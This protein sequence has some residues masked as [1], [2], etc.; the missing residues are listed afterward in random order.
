MKIAKKLACLLLTGM[1]LLAQVPL[2]SFAGTSESGENAGDFYFTENTLTITSKNGFEL[3]DYLLNDVSSQVLYDVIDGDVIKVDENG[4]VTVVGNGGPVT[5]TARAEMKG[6]DTK[7]CTISTISTL[8]NGQSTRSEISTT[9]TVEVLY[10]YTTTMKIKVNLPDEESSG[11]DSSS[12]GSSG[13]GGGRSGLS[14]AANGGTF[15]SSSGA[16]V[17]ISTHYLGNGVRLI[18]GTI[19]LGGKTINVQDKI[20]PMPDGSIVR[21]YSVDGD[22]SGLTFAGGGVVSEDGATIKTPEGKVFMMTYATMCIVTDV[23]GVSTGCF[24]NPETGQPVAFGEDTVLMQLGLDGQVHAHFINP[25]GYFY[26][27]TVT[28]NGSTFAFNEEG[29]MISYV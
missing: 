24:L 19:S 2:T 22:M 1:I 4:N 29:I 23:N 16:M 26:T 20:T 7:I 9:S 15:Q 27:G 3:N 8:E 25:Q 12:G 11:D 6:E 5:V 21:L 28:M 13:G 18:T 14:A 17:T 10:K